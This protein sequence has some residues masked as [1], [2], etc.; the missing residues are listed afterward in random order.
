MQQLRQ[1]AA[2]FVMT[3]GVYFGLPGVDPWDIRRDARSYS[4]PHPIVAH[5]PCQRWGRYWHGGPSALIRRTLGDDGGAFASA[6]ASVRA[7]GGVLEHPEA[8]HAFAHYGLHKPSWRAGWEDAGDGVGSV[9]CVAQAHYGHRARKLTWLYAVGA[10]L[11]ALCWSIPAPTSRLDYG[12]HS[13]EERAARKHA[14]APK[15]NASR[16]TSEENNATP[17][18]FRDVL[19]G[20][21]RSVELRRARPAAS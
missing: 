11:P 19:I 18:A 20:M 15:V 14:V 17:I 6:L 10:M 5:P 9:C 21:A 12:F 2:L 7:Y 13:A 1:V 3:D 4:G 8:S 16:L